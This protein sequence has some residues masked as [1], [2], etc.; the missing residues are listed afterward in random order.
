MFCET[1]KKD[2]TKLS[3]LKRKKQTMQNVNALKKSTYN[4]LYMN[5]VSQEPACADD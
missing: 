3:V 5:W 1:H 4:K 2:F